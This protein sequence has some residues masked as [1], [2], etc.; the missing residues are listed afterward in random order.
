[1]SE[2][3]EDIKLK[4]AWQTAFELRTCPDNTTLHVADPDENLKKH[5]AICHVCRD[6]R[7]MNQDERDAWRTLRETFAGAVMKP[8]RGTEKQVGQ[9]WTVKKEFGGWREDGRY[10][11]PPGVLLLEKIEGTSGWRVAQL[12]FDKQMMGDG[13]IALDEQY[14]F[15]ET[16]NCYSL[17]DD[18]FDLFLG[19]IPTND[20]N[21]VLAVSFAVHESAPEGSI[22]SFF[23]SMEIEVGAF[24]AVPAVAELVVEWEG[25]AEEVIEVIK[26]R[27]KVIVSGFAIV[28]DIAADMLVPLRNTFEPI[29]R[30]TI[31]SVGAKLTDEQKRLLEKYCQVIP[32]D[33]KLADE[34]LTVI[35]EWLWK[36]PV[37]PP[38]VRVVFND[39]DLSNGG[40]ISS[41]VGKIVA[42]HSLLFNFTTSEISKFKLKYIDKVL[43]LEIYGRHHE[44]Y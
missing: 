25:V 31:K 35:L 40:V 7:E 34:T 26:D 39:F 37:D 4:L 13:D 33:V 21:Q 30:G 27:I 42:Q 22:L 3:N 5:L 9:V 43:T 36:E 8:G 20:L 44:L 15:A 23:R 14:G 16:W 6:K 19:V 10:S 38:V 11:R 12:Y 1:M 41:D 18:R 28:L 2:H 32:I 24:V 17:K 29:T